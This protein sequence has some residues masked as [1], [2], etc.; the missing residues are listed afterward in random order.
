[1]L[2]CNHLSCLLRCFSRRC[3]AHRPSKGNKMERENYIPGQMAPGQKED[4]H[5]S[6]LCPRPRG[7]LC[8]S[9]GTGGGEGRDA[10]FKRSG[11][12]STVAI[13]SLRSDIYFIQARGFPDGSDGKESASNAEDLGSIPGLGR[14]PGEGNGYPLQYSCLEN[15]MDRGAWRA[16]VRGIARVGH[17]QST[18]TFTFHFIQAEL[19]SSV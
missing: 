6:S 16:T 7:T 10:R 18:N 1:M 3:P 12:S 15:P 19:K 13:T 5:H 8:Q 14:S 11:F 2:G 17:Y 4:T 9:V